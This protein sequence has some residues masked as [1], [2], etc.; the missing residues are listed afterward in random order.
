MPPASAA[1]LFCSVYAY[2]SVPP[3]VL[4]Y[5]PLSC[6]FSAYIGTTFIHPLLIFYPLKFTF[7]PPRSPSPAL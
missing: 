6:L 3:P 4:F 2:L 1:A 5:L 7:H